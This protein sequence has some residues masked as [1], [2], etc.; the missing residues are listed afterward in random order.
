MEFIDIKLAS[1]ELEDRI[2]SRLRSIVS[3]SDYIMGKEI[4]VLEKKLADFVQVDHAVTVSS[5][6]DA[7]LVALLAIGIGPGDE[8]ITSS[9]SFFSTVE[10]I[11]ILGAKPIFVDIDPT[12]YNLDSNLLEL[13]VT[14]KTKAIIPVSLYGQ[15]ADFDEINEIA[16][17]AK[18]VVI[19]D[20]AQS[21]GATYKG[22]RSGALSA[23]GCTSFFPS[24]PL[25]C[26]GDGGACFTSDQELAQKMREIR[27]HGQSKRYLHTQLGLNARMDTLQ[28]A[29]LLEK[30]DGF[31]QEVESRQQVAKRYDMLLSKR[32]KKQKIHSYNTSVYAQYTIEVG[33]REMIQSELAKRNIPTAIHYPLSMTEQPILKKL[34]NYAMSFPRTESASKRVLS[35]PMH[36]YLT[37]IDQTYI[38]SQLDAVLDRVEIE[39]F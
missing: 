29:V 4:G 15:C 9:F 13:A 18:L 23:I 30:L 12:T 5:G 20:G 31:Q 1:Q 21:F 6:T 2:F 10:C 11:L 17:K 22:K 19:E 7:L 25:G 36:P 24:K 14:K 32:I 37:E 16:E 28:A 3:R 35:L 27:V 26:F 8:V 33:N 39:Q 38:V 34:Y